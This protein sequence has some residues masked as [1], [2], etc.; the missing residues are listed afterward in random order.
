MNRI[1][2]R[3]SRSWSEAPVER[4]P[5]ELMANQYERRQ[6]CCQESRCQHRFLGVLGMEH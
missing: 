3:S 4:F 1:V 2:A 6:A 5:N